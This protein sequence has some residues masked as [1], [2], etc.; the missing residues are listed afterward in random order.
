MVIDL[1]I[2]IMETMGI[3][4]ITN[5]LIKFTKISSVLILLML[6]GL[7]ILTFIPGVIHLIKD[8][9]YSEIKTTAILLVV[10]YFMFLSFKLMGIF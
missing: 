6:F 9:D 1:F 8:N 10:F 4:D 2:V 5:E 7:T 3:M